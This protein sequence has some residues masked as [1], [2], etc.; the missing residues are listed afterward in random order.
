M[1]L[2]L[3]EASWSKFAPLPVQVPFHQGAERVRCAFDLHALLGSRVAAEFDRRM[4]LAGDLP[5]PSNLDRR[6]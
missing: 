3:P 5:R 2:D 6:R 4:V 1:P